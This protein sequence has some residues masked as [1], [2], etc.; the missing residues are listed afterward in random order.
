MISRYMLGLTLLTK[1]LWSKIAMAAALV[2]TVLAVTATPQPAEARRHCPLVLFPACV[3]NP[4]GGQSTIATNRCLAR[5]RHIPVLHGG[6]CVGPVCDLLP[7]NPV[8]ALD[9]RHG[10]RTFSTLCWAEINN[11]VFLYNGVCQ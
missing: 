5:V 3:V 6:P 11:A 8:C 7:W 2:A 9:P 10:P 4:A 1:R